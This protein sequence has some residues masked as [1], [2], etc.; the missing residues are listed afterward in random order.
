MLSLKRFF[1]SGIICSLFWL[2]WPSA[3]FSQEEEPLPSP[4][5]I[6]IA[7][8]LNALERLI[9]DT[10][11]ENEVQMRQLADLQANLSEQEAILNEREASMNEQERLLEGL[12]EQLREMSRIYREQSDLS[13]SYERSSRFWRRFTLIGVP[14]AVVISGLVT[15]LVMGLGR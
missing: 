2:V 7:E 9:E 15:G 11:S 4:D 6:G 14:A 3:V 5:F 12:R 8:N 13:G 1:L 10:L